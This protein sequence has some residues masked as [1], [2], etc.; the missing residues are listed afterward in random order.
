M[1]D[2]NRLSFDNRA[3]MFFLLFLSFAM[4][5]ISGVLLDDIPFKNEMLAKIV[6][7]VF[8]KVGVSI[9]FLTAIFHIYYNWKA[10][11]RYFK[12]G[13]NFKYLKEFAVSVI[14]IA[15][16]TIISTCYTYYH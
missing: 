4:M 14:L 5:I 9:F 11:L 7:K 12:K 2:T 10:F 1:Q 15:I 13:N 16:V 8:H 3:L 6:S